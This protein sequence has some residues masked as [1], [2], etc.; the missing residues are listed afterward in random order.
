MSDA[1][2]LFDEMGM[3]SVMSNFMSTMEDSGLF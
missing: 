2:E 1:E 3:R